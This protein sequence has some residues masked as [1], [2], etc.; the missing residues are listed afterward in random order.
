MAANP[1]DRQFRLSDFRFVT[2]LL[3]E[4]QTREDGARDRIAKKHG[5]QKSVITGRVGR[6]EKFLGT[7]LFSGPQ[8]KSPTAA[9]RELA[10]RGPQFLRMVEDFVAMIGDVDERERGEVRRLRHR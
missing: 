5:I 2:E 10:T 6:I 3:A 8:R 7:T 9:G 4:A 1:K